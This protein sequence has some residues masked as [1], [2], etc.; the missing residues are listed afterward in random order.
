MYT[1]QV[2][3]PKAGKPLVTPEPT[4]KAF[5]T[6]KIGCSALVTFQPTSVLPYFARYRLLGDHNV[7]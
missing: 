4:T 7:S 2:P 3:Q 5:L 1:I 6:D